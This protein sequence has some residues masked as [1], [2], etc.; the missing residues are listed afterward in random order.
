VVEGTKGEWRVDPEA[1]GEDFEGR[2]ALVASTFP[3][4]RSSSS[5][6]RAR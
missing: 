1:L 5:T 6:G 3:I 2:T 4:S